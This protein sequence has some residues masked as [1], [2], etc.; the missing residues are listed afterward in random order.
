MAGA[1][2]RDDSLS[3]GRT[4]EAA[5]VKPPP[6]LSSRDMRPR[7]E[8]SQPF[9]AGVVGSV[10]AAVAGGGSFLSVRSAAGLRT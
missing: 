7:Q 8:L 1:P 5:R 9:R 6:P 2:S 3:R 10:E 4:S